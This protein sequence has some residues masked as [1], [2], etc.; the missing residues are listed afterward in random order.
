M[1][2]TTTSNGSKKNGDG[3]DSSFSWFE[4]F[5]SVFKEICNRSDKRR[6]IHS[7]KVGVALVLVSLLYLVNSMFKQIGENA[8]WAIMTVVVMFELYAGATL[9][10]G[11]NRGVG[12][13][14]GGGM[15]CLAAVLAAENGGIAKPTIVVI[16][17][18]AYGTVATYYRM[19]PNIK[20][21]YDY[22]F[23]ISIL[24]FNLVAVSGVRAEKVV[25]VARDRL[26]AIGMGFILCIFVNLF[27]FPIWASNDLHFSTSSKFNKLANSIQG[28]FDEYFKLG[29][30]KEIHDK[31][32]DGSA[33]ILACKIVI[34]SK[35]NDEALANHAKWEPWHGKFGLYYP[36]DKYL[37]IGEHLRELAATIISLKGCLQSPKQPLP[38]KRQMLK[39]Q[40][41]DFLLSMIW[42]LNEIGDTIGK[43]EK[44]QT[45]LSINP[46]LQLLKL[47]LSPPGPFSCKIEVVETDENLAI[48]SSNFLMLEIVEKVEILAAKVEELGE[49]ANFR[50]TKMDV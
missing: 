28:C 24:T 12:T 3:N 15:G 43:M 19:V 35:S 17:L 9:S 16:S 50:A 29:S 49:I 45:K 46:K 32:G 40:C 5:A 36:W 42:I 38:L 20:K 33:S 26:A 10:K 25:E 18:F 41:D 27:I 37:E 4:G 1:S 30:D 48:L 47:Q 23:M 8:M 13:L 2:S 21:R 14:I 34:N 6:I 39:G 11:I 31:V 22:G 7:I 44:C